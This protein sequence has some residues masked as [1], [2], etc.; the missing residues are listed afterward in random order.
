MKLSPGSCMLMTSD[1]RFYN[2]S[3]RFTSAD[4]E[5]DQK[6]D[7]DIRNRAV[8]MILSRQQ[9]GNSGAENERQVTSDIIYDLAT[10]HA[11][12]L[13]EQD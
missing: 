6:I 8:S 1:D 3:Y 7:G 11:C 4:S 12:T 10:T 13:D 9:S 2:F 5:E